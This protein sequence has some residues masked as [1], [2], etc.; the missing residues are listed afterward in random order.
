MDIESKPISF[1]LWIEERQKVLWAY[2]KTSK[3]YP[4]EL[5]DE[6]SFLDRM[7]REWENRN[8]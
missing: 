3:H 2:I 5:I 1:E 7:R 8:A 6:F 4:G